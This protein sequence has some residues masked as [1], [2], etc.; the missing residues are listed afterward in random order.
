MNKQVSFK[1]L[2]LIDY[3]Q[4]WDFQEEL[5]KSVVDVKIK[6]RRQSLD[7]PTSNYLLFV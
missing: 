6:N 4:C 2:G 7:L 5:F 1:D 3:K